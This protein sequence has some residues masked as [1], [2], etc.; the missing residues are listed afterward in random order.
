MKRMKL[1]IFLVRK[2]GHIAG[3]WLSQGF[4]VDGL[5]SLHNTKPLL[6]T[7]Y[8]QG[9]VLGARNTVRQSSCP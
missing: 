6:S 5:C 8:M 2:Q 1:T 3:D 7:Y 4:S 9:M